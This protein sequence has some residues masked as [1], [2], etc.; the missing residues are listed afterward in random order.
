MLIKNSK[1]KKKRKLRDKTELWILN[2]HSTENRCEDDWMVDGDV[3]WEC[4]VYRTICISFSNS[5]SS[6]NLYMT[7]FSW[8]CLLIR[9]T[10]AESNTWRQMRQDLALNFERVCVFVHRATLLHKPHTNRFEGMNEEKGRIWKI[11][12]NYHSKTRPFIRLTHQSNRPQLFELRSQEPHTDAPPTYK[13]K[14]QAMQ[15]YQSI[16]L[17]HKTLAFVLH[18]CFTIFKSFRS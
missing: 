6:Y 10:F 2:Q 3:H 17:Y 1:K 8:L 7:K 16:S 4:H 11:K 5:N 9:Y 12:F 18:S 13:K 14:A 15:C